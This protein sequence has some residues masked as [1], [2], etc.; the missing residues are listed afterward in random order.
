MPD[1]NESHPLTL[2]IAAK[3]YH[4]LMLFATYGKA[5]AYL[6]G[7]IV[8]LG[9]VGLWWSGLGIVWLPVGIIAAAFSIALMRCF[10]E[11]ID[12][13]VDTMIPK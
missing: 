9:A 2:P 13:I 8:L 3:P 5:I 11:L 4:A 10:A 7:A 12:L 6:T 1:K